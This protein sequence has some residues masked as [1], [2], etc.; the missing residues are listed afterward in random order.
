MRAAA[1]LALCAALAG[2]GGSG[3]ARRTVE[4]AGFTGVSATAGI[5]VVISTSTAWSVG[6]AA[7][8]LAMDRIVV[9]VRGSTLWLGL[10]PGTAARA[11][12]LASQARVD[13]TLPSLSRLEVTDGSRARL[14]LSQPAAD[15]AVELSRGSQV[16]GTLAC[17]ELVIAATGSSIVELAGTAERITL[18]GSDRAKLRLSSLETPSMSAI[19]SGGSTA[20]VSVSRELVVEASGDS[21]LSFRG[22][23][24]V[25]RQTLSG[26]SWLRR[27]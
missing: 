2:C 18:A 26:G 5:D 19:L 1:L 23:A 20:A 7:D 11:R 24:R 13:V 9:E 25:E 10:R 22:D 14:S 21:G 16:S 4:A 6:L 8:R 17:A 15:L 12:W 27:E 3:P